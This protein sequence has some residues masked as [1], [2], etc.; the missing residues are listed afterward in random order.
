MCGYVA[1]VCPFPRSHEPGVGVIRV[2]M[3][4]GASVRPE[5]GVACTGQ[6]CCVVR[7]GGVYV[8]SV[9]AF[10]GRPFISFR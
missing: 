4:Q 8:V 3:C 7:A 2:S 9:A 6:D 10:G 1:Y 5:I